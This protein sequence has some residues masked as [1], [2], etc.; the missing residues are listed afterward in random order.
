MAKA[1]VG[2]VSL[3]V[4]M[5]DGRIALDDPAAKYVPQWQD[6]P[7][8]SKI[9]VRQLGS[10]TSG[11]EDAEADDLPHE[12]AHRLERRLLEAARGARD[13]FTLSRDAAPVL[14]EPGTKMAYSNPGIAM[15]TYCVTAALRDAPHK[16]IRTLLRDRVM[17]PIGVPDGEWS[18]GYGKTSMV[19]GLPLV[20][21]WGGG[22]YTARATARV[23]RLMLREGIGKADRLLSPEAVRQITRDA[24]TPGNCGIGWWSNNEGECA[25]VAEG[26]VLGFGRRTPDR[27]G[28]AQ[29][30]SDR[31]AQRRDVECPRRRRA[32]RIS[33]SRCAGSCSSH[34]LT[35]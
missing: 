18:V 14:F 28:R 19:D 15:L 23:G 3:A 26:R 27:A 33:T 20:G 12:Q 31:R 17:R 8:K 22:N 16:D 35:P 5:T 6:D 11:I 29:P 13:P 32:K 30:Q 7:R 25:E 2:G 4:A 21:S 24:G 10:H 9:T 1:I 34:W